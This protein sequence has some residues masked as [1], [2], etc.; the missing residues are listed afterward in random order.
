VAKV[1]SNVNGDAA[2]SFDRQAD[3][4]SGSVSCVEA[5]LVTAIVMDD[6]GNTLLVLRSRVFAPPKT[7]ANVVQG[8]SAQEKTLTGAVKPDRPWNRHPAFWF[9]AAGVAVA[10]ASVFGGRLIG[11][12]NELERVDR[13]PSEY[14]VQMLRQLESEALLNRAVMAT[15]ATLALVFAVGGVWTW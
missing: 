11:N 9:S 14:D 13:V 5:C 2:S 12:V 7:E 15:G 6:S 8:P 1:V 10:V 4:F 3:Q